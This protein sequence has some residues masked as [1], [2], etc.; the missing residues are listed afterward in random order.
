[1]VNVN[2]CNYYLLPSC[3]ILRLMMSLMLGFSGPHPL[4][5]IDQSEM[6][7]E[8]SSDNDSEK[9]NWNVHTLLLRSLSKCNLYFYSAR[10][11]SSDQKRQ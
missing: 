9:S 11:H 10:M 8:A 4:L 6:H 7:T 5:P 3:N 2:V 1:M